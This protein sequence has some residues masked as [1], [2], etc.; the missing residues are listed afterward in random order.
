MVLQKKLK[1]LVKLCIAEDSIRISQSMYEKLNDLKFGNISYD[2]CLYA[3]CSTLV[4]MYAKPFGKNNIIGRLTHK[5]IKCNLTKKEKSI[6]KILLREW[7]NKIYAH[8]DMKHFQ[9]FLSL[10]GNKIQ[11]Q[12]TFH[13]IP[14][15]DIN[16]QTH[17]FEKSST[18]CSIGKLSVK[19][20][21]HIREEKNNLLQS[22]FDSN[23]IRN[24]NGWGIYLKNVNKFCV[25]IFRNR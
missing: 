4:I 14:V 16:L 9:I 1:K 17:S 6:H 19:T 8:A 13:T 25:E 23:E 2:D 10:N 18:F 5:A 11:S 7:R 20:L 3:L 22:D 21:K 24:D 12:S 15:F